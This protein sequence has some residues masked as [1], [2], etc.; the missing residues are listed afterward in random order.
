[1]GLSRPE[2]HRGPQLS[3]PVPDLSLQ[4]VVDWIHAYYTRRDADLVDLAHPE[5]EL[6]PRP[7]LTPGRVYRG[8]SGIWQ[9]LADT[10]A[11]R[12]AVDSFSLAQLPTAG[13]W[14]AVTP[15]GS[16]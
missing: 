3:P 6:S 12:L 2:V 14:R 10:A 9:W 1:M 16:T 7:D 4:L 11:T 5:I 13:C 8:R 15:T